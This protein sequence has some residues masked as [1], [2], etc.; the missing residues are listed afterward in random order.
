[1]SAICVLMTAMAITDI[2]SILGVGNR[3]ETLNR[4]P[5]MTHIRWKEVKCMAMHHRDSVAVHVC[6][7]LTTS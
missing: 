7:L 1:M 2:G 5:H 4:S 6:L 3:V